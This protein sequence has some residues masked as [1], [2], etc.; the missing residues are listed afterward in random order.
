VRD[1]RENLEPV[2]TEVGRALR[3]RR[4][5]VVA[6]DDGSTD[7]SLDELRALRRRHPALRVFALS[8]PAGQSA[9]LAVGWDR[10]RAPIVVTLD[11]DGQ[12]DPGD[13]PRLLDALG[14]DPALAMVAGRRA[15]RRDSPWKL[16]QSRLANA[17]RDR[18]TGHRVSDTGCGLK[19]AHRAALVGLPRFDGMHRFLPTLVTLAGGRVTEL[20]VSHRPRRWG[21]SKYGARNRAA[22]ALRDAFGVRWLASRR[23]HAEAHEVAD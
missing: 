19:A 9:A 4:Y 12:Y 18:V 6:V 14:G 21:R 22:R 1:E 3:D 11:A 10:A 7:G 17:V 2:L 8:R 20:G 16:F 15:E 5:E 13:I 23:L